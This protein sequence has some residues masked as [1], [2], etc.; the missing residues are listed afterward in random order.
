MINN[1]LRI[2]VSFAQRLS[3]FFGKTPKYWIDLQTAY[4]LSALSEDKKEAA[5]LK[6]IPRAVKTPATKKAAAKTTAKKTP[7]RK[8]G[9]GRPAKKV[10][11]K[12][13]AAK[14]AASKKA[15]AGKTAAKK[16]GAPRGRRP[17]KN[18]APKAATTAPDPSPAPLSPWTPPTSSSSDY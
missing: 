8:A 18:V 2:S 14:K 5:I 7:G 17:V 12:P 13:V 3:K 10:A 11:A 16:T 1:K 6:T 15:P 9:P 4:E